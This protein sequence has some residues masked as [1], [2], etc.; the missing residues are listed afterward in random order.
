[1]GKTSLIA[2]VVN[3]DYAMAGVLVVCVKVCERG[4]KRQMIFGFSVLKL[5]ILSSVLHVLKVGP[6][7]KKGYGYGSLQLERAQLRA[8][9]LFPTS[10]DLC[11]LTNGMNQALN[12][13]PSAAVCD[14]DLPCLLA[15]RWEILPSSTLDG[16][17]GL[18]SQQKGTGRLVWE[19][20]P[21]MSGVYVVLSLPTSLAKPKHQS[22]LDLTPFSSLSLTPAASSKCLF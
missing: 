14:D 8:G 19:M 20:V 17:Q 6:G 21:F 22:I 15:L 1:M 12:E 10:S 18:C 2:V 16:L 3:E 7:E 4:T 13:V 11:T 5:Y 9:C